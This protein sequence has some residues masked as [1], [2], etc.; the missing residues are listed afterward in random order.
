MRP[1]PITVTDATSPLAPMAS[2]RRDPATKGYLSTTQRRGNGN[3]EEPPR[4][5][6]LRLAFARAGHL[7]VAKKIDVRPQARVQPV[8]HLAACINQSSPKCPTRWGG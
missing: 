1:T 8:I 3:G 4:M 6:T 7:L 5:G 2:G